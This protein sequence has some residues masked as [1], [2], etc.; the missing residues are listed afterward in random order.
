MRSEHEICGLNAL[1]GETDIF[2]LQLEVANVNAASFLGWL[3]PNTNEWVNAVL[4]NIG[5]TVQFAGDHAYD[6][7]SDFILGRYGVDTTNKTVWAVLNHNSDFA[8][9]IPEP[10]TMAML[11]LGGGLLTLRRRKRQF[12]RLFST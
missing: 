7:G 4:G 2:V 11:A 8:A 12:R 10:T 6:A 9:A 3:D 1:T 5:G